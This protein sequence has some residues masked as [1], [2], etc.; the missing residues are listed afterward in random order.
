MLRPQA[1]SLKQHM[2]FWRDMIILIWP[3][4]HP[5]EKQYLVTETGRGG[6]SWTR[7]LVYG[8]PG[9]EVDKAWYDLIKRM[10]CELTI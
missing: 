5:D 7:Y 9:P 4:P 8:G 2:L 1:V 3:V 6:H 10:S